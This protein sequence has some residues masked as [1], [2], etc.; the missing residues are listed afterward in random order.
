MKFININFKIVINIILITLM[1]VSLA[2]PL[3]GQPNNDPLPYEI[4]TKSTNGEK[5]SRRGALSGKTIY[6]SAG[7]GKVWSR[8]YGEWIKD[9]YSNSDGYNEGEYTAFFLNNYLIPYL[10]NT[11]ADVITLRERDENDVSVINSSPELING[12]NYNWQKTPVPVIDGEKIKYKDIFYKIDTTRNKQTDVKAIWKIDKGDFKEGIYALYLWYPIADQVNNP[13]CDAHYIIEHAY[14][15]TEVY[16]DQ[17]KHGLAWR[18]IGSYPV[19]PAKPIDE[20]GDIIFRVTLDNYSANYFNKSNTVVTAGA[21]RL[22]GGKLDNLNGF[23]MG[24][25]TT[26]GNDSNSNPPISFPDQPLQSWW[27]MKSWY[28]LQQTPVLYDNPEL[29]DLKYFN[30]F[31]SYDSVINYPTTTDVASRWVFWQYD[32]IIQSGSS[33]E[34]AVYIMWH[35]D[36]GDGQQT[37]TYRYEWRINPLRDLPDE[38]YEIE[39]PKHDYPGIGEISKDELLQQYFGEEL[40]EELRNEGFFEERIVNKLI[41]VQNNQYGEIYQLPYNI[42]GLLVEIGRHLV[43]AERDL[44]RSDEFNN[45]VA[46]ATYKAIVRYFAEKDKQSGKT[47]NSTIIPEHPINIIINKTYNISSYKWI[48]LSWEKPPFNSNTNSNDDIYGDEPERYRVYYCTTDGNPIWNPNMPYH[49]IT[50][51]DEIENIEENKIIINTG[52]FFFL[53]NDKPLWIW[54]SALN[55]GGES[56]PSY[57]KHVIGDGFISYNISSSLSASSNNAVKKFTLTSWSNSAGLDY[58][59]SKDTND[60]LSNAMLASANNNININNVAINGTQIP[61]DTAPGQKVIVDEFEVPFNQSVYKEY[62]IYDKAGNVKIIKQNFSNYGTETP[63]SDHPDDNYSSANPY[64]KDSELPPGVNFDAPVG[65]IM[66]GFYSEASVLVNKAGENTGLVFTDFDPWET[67]EQ[68]PVLIIPSGALYGMENADS[69]RARLEEYTK[70][71]GKLIVFS[72]QYGNEYSILP[73]GKVNGYGWQQDMSCYSSSLYLSNWHPILSGF[74]TA[75]MSS[76]VDGYFTNF[77]ENS[78]IMLSRSVNGQPGAAFYKYPDDSGSGWVFASDIFDD[79]GT[80][81]GQQ[82]N[83]A[84]ILLRNLLTYAISSV[85]DEVDAEILEFSKGEDINLNLS[86]FNPNSYPVEEVSLRIVSPER[87]ICGDLQTI[88]ATI[89]AGESIEVPVTIPV[90]TL[91]IPINEGVSNGLGIWRID[92]TFDQLSD[93]PDLINESYHFNQAGRFI[94]SDPAEQVD[95]NGVS[96]SITSTQSYFVGDTTADFTFHVYNHSDQVRNATIHYGLPHHTW[97]SGKRDLYGNFYDFTHT[98]ENIQP[99]DKATYVWSVPVFTT[100]RLWSYIEENGRTLAYAAYPVFRGYPNADISV[101]Q[102]NGYAIPGQSCPVTVKL[103]NKNS[104]GWGGY[105]SIDLRSPKG[106][107]IPIIEKGPFSFIDGGQILNLLKTVDVPDTI[108]SGTYSLIVSVYGTTEKFAFS[109][110]ADFLI[111]ESPLTFNTIYPPVFYPGTE[112]NITIDVSNDSSFIPVANGSFSLELVDSKGNHIPLFNTDSPIALDPGGSTVFTIPLTIPE[113]REGEYSFNFIYEDEFSHKEWSEKKKSDIYSKLRFENKE[114][115]GGADLV[116]YLEIENTGDF[117]EALDITINIPDIDYTGE[118]EITL[119]PEDEKTRLDYTAL[120]PETITSGLHTVNVVITQAGGNEIKYTYNFG[121]IKPELNAILETSEATAGETIELLLRNTGG[122]VAAGSYKLHIEDNEQNEILSQTDTIQQLYPDNDDNVEI[123]LPPTCKSGQYYLFVKTNEAQTSKENDFIF[124]IEVTGKNVEIETY[125]D[126]LIYTNI[127]PVEVLTEITLD[128]ELTQFDGQLH[129]EIEKASQDMQSIPF[130]PGYG[131]A[132]S[133]V[134]F[135]FI[136]PDGRK[137]FG[138]ENGLSVLDN[139]NTP[140]DYSDDAWITFNTSDGLVDN[141][142]LSI[143]IDSF[144]NKWIG[145]N[146]G[147]SKLDDNGTPFNKNDDK[148]FT[149]FKDEKEDSTNKIYS[150]KIDQWDNKWFI[151]NGQKVMAFKDTNYS[152]DSALDLLAEAPGSLI[153]IIDKSIEIDRQIFSY[154]LNIDNENKIWVSWTGDYNVE[155]WDQNC[156]TLDAISC[157]DDPL[158]GGNPSIQ[159]FYY[160]RYYISESF[161]ESLIAFDPS[162]TKWIAR[163]N[164][165]VAFDDKNTPSETYDDEWQYFTFNIDSTKYWLTDDIKRPVPNIQNTENPARSIILDGQ[166]NKWLARGHYLVVFND[167]G[168]PFGWDDY[169]WNYFPITEDESV[170]ISSL[171]IDNLGNKWI[172]TN[173]GVYILNDNQTPFDSTDDEWSPILSN[174]EEQLNVNQVVSDDLHNKWAAT[175]NGVYVIQDNSTI[176]DLS[177]DRKQAFNIEDGLTNNNVHCIAIDNNGNKWFA[178]SSGIRVLDDN[179]TLFNKEDDEW[180]SYTTDEGLSSNEILYIAIDSLQQK[181][182]ATNAGIDIIDEQG[183]IHNILSIGNLELNNVKKIIID[184]DGVKWCFTSYG[185]VAFKEKESL[186][187]YDWIVYYNQDNVLDCSLIYT[188]YKGNNG[189]LWISTDQGIRLLDTGDNPFNNSDDI[190]NTINLFA[191]PISCNSI[192]QDTNGIV[193]LGI[194]G[195]GIKN[196]VKYDIKGT[197]LIPEDDIWK[198]FSI[199]SKLTENYVNSLLVDE[200]TL[201]TGTSNGLYALTDETTKIWENDH[202]INQGIKTDTINDEPGIINSTGKYYVSGVLTNTLGQSIAYSRNTFYIVDHDI[203]LEMSFDKEYYSPEESMIITYKITNNSNVDY[204]DKRILFYQDNEIIH[205]ST[206]FNVPANGYIDGDILCNAP[207]N[208]KITNIQIKF[209]DIEINEDIQIIKPDLIL[210][211]NSPEEV[212]RNPFKLEIQIVNPTLIDINA[213]IHIEPSDTSLEPYTSEPLLMEKGKTLYIEKEYSITQNTVF[214]ISAGEYKSQSITVNFGESG[215]VQIMPSPVYQEGNISIPYV[216]NNTGTLPA[217]FNVYV[218]LTKDSEVIWE[219]ELIEIVPAEASQNS[220]ISLNLIKGTYTLTYSSHFG[221]EGHTFEVL[222]E[223]DLGMDIGVGDCEDNY[224]PVTVNMTNNGFSDFNGFLTIETSFFNTIQPVEIER[225]NNGQAGTDSV[226]IYINIE[227]APTGSDKIKIMIKDN[228][229]NILK[230]EERLI[231]IIGANVEVELLETE[232]L[233][234]G[235]VE[236]LSFK[237]KN[238]GQQNTTVEFMFDFG[239]FKNETKR[240]ILPGGEEVIQD[241]TFFLPAGLET[242]EYTAKYKLT[243]DNE[244]IEDTIILQVNGLD[245]DVSVDWD[246]AG[247]TEGETAVLSV[248]IKNQ[249]DNEIPELYLET[250]YHGEKQKHPFTLTGQEETTINVQLTAYGDDN[251]LVFY[252]IYDELENRGIYLNTTYLY[253]FFDDVTIIPDKSVY[254][255][256]EV[257]HAN[258]YTSQS[259]MLSITGPGYVESIELQGNDTDISFQLPGTLTRGT[260]TLVYSLDGGNTHTTPFDIDALWIR[261]TE[262]NL[263]KSKYLDGDNVE[264]S[265]NIDCT[266]NVEVEL[267]SFIIY[268]NQEISNMESMDINLLDSEKNRIIL[269]HP[270]ETNY[271]GIH[272]LVY[273]FV[274]KENPEVV[275]SSAVEAFEV[276]DIT[277]MSLKTDKNQYSS[278]EES[279]IATLQVYSSVQ[280]SGSLEILIDDISMISQA[281]EIPEGINIIELDIPVSGL[282]GSHSLKAEM[283]VDGLKSSKST[284]F[285]YEEQLSDLIANVPFITQ[286]TDTDCTVVVRVDNYG[287]VASSEAS[288][289]LWEITPDQSRVKIGSAVLSEIEVNGSLQLEFIW[290]ITGKTGSY[291]L[292]VVVDPDGIISEYSESNNSA[293]NDILLPFNRLPIANAG[294]DIVVEATSIDGTPVTLDGSQSYDPDQNTLSYI[295]I[296]SNNYYETVNPTLS[297]PLG[298]HEVTLWVYDGED[299]SE[300][301]DTILVTV[302]DTTPPVLI[303]PGDIQ[304]PA[305]GELTEVEIGQASATDIF[306]VDITNNAPDSFPVGVTTVTWTATDANGNITTGTQKITVTDGEIPENEV[307]VKFM[308]S[309]GGGIKGGIVQYYYRQHKSRRFYKMKYL[310]KTDEQGILLKE[311]PNGIYLFKI[312]YR[313]A[314]EYKWQNITDNRIVIFQTKRITISVKNKYDSPVENALVGYYIYWKYN[315]IGHTD[316]NGL[317]TVELLKGKYLFYVEYKRKKYFKNVKIEENTEIDFKI[318]QNY[319]HH[320]NKNPGKKLKKSKH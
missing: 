58:A 194:T 10:E 45:S 319:S 126:K 239:D 297:L 286:K 182:I 192:Y 256:G 21:I 262:S 98:I 260:Y 77:P 218:Q 206:L 20:E 234:A 229:G 176:S 76:N 1:F 127:E 208:Q 106:T 142:V 92:A 50:N 107:I 316:D 70:L 179:D 204:M 5:Q 224:I 87:M 221:N 216:F 284:S 64:S 108:N 238:S 15:G 209:M 4:I 252:G 117:S 33:A 191:D 203:S 166:G 275:L 242:G 299:Y 254:R 83:D 277:I 111:P 69:F 104:Y 201:W 124:G 12:N 105:F 48:S 292:E 7:H 135:V 223:F 296:W 37:S 184:A 198:Y 145:T 100:D 149:Y 226:K 302:R 125:T 219:D 88:T 93:N 102:E 78:K 35:T 232:S 291:I 225:N 282:S 136:D 200:E 196:L 180:Q 247:F 99:G 96:L 140:F 187:D 274:S 244:I 306:P 151:L 315:A 263:S 138:T 214:N 103:T 293:V 212:G 310:G 210:K 199:D 156:I 52:R 178:T 49:E 265:L 259:G 298:E 79:W 23:I 175:S 141:K 40:I 68:Y 272:Y 13:T 94:V 270:L 62:Y 123:K 14:G 61:L 16:V 95:P 193:W 287:A 56:L 73:G 267:R 129:V 253:S 309:N 84:V 164:C 17:S 230:E 185:L 25:T 304:V 19:D 161:E 146:N 80:G 177:D 47:W 288:V 233:S 131:L 139:R 168:S 228:A 59:I 154:S 243:T 153:I 211:V 81:R 215:T 320:V 72:Q 134:N 120:L 65:I 54:V 235:Q 2:F 167:N 311:L 281:C 246:K 213:I 160:W 39:V 236:T 147:L 241:F 172:T 189:E 197:P 43:E 294:D 114:N 8:S 110:R 133:I 314:S 31:L 308:D 264:L 188:L 279:I 248:N 29:R 163:G 251:N 122:S 271:S 44:F 250:S 60:D 307:M 11:G 46:Q 137:W 217:E 240:I 89:P 220:E 157:D 55:D 257:L 289:D 22:G 112:T 183:E 303:V 317:I 57:P 245:L 9:S 6:L 273:Q 159:S 32:N 255:P 36:A 101:I 155:N 174:I 38:D 42:P 91:S 53:P 90:S 132:D 41:A 305:T 121:I 283:E 150:V 82:N 119:D 63:D 276:G 249:S 130:L 280:T 26:E 318:N 128:D 86:I 34:D 313:G 118:G 144:G 162:G 24:Y 51:F 195:N 295:W 258:I 97:E 30:E 227:N 85:G 169:Q 261:V 148:W 278:G 268:P 300:S 74:D 71:G 222:P 269:S 171:S 152:T 113:A 266:E 28:N 202:N 116:M 3:N 18:Y 66:K 301:S 237:L 285:I 173:N 190:W 158:S 290:N 27:E 186:E 165:M 109:K 312:T 170:K 143:T 205:T 181:W 75:Y 115:R 67:Y 231:T 207:E